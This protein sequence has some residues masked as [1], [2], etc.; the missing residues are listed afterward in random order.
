M[1]SFRLLVSNL[2]AASGRETDVDKFFINDQKTADCG[3]F[4]TM[5]LSCVSVCMYVYVCVFQRKTD[6][7]VNPKFGIV[8]VFVFGEYACASPFTAA[9]PQVF[10]CAVLLYV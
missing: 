3:S 7:T 2:L 8:C 1:S 4:L 5:H 6:Y 10:V 9:A